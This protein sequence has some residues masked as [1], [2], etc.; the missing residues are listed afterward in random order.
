MVQAT[1]CHRLYMIDVEV[2]FDIDVYESKEGTHTH[3]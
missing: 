2:K 1:G 3:R